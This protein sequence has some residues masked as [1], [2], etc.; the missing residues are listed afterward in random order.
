MNKII[1]IIL[2]LITGTVYAQTG[3]VLQDASM[4][5][6]AVSS[7]AEEI[8]AAMFAGAMDNTSGGNPLVDL[9]QNINLIAMIV[10]GIL[11]TYQIINAF[12]A[13]AHE[14]EFL[15]KKVNA[16]TYPLRIALASAV[17]V[18]IKSGYA[19]VQIVVMWLV[20]QSIGFADQTWISYIT[21]PNFNKNLDIRVSSVQSK[22]LASAILESTVCLE[23]LKKVTAPVPGNPITAEHNWGMHQTKNDATSTIKVF[24]DLNQAQGFRVD[25]CGLIDI[26]SPNNLFKQNEREN[27]AVETTVGTDYKKNSELTVIQATVIAAH[28]TA[29]DKMISSL[30][31]MAKEMIDNPEQEFNG[32]RFN[33]IV[34]EYNLYISEFAEKEMMKYDVYKTVKEQAINDGFISSMFLYNKMA[35]MA[36]IVGRSIVPQST[37][38]KPLAMTNSTYKDQYDIYM[39]KINGKLL[40]TSIKVSASPS[41]LEE[42]NEWSIR[43]WVENK[44]AEEV[45]GGAFQIYP[46]EHPIM[47]A[48]RMGTNLLNTTIGIT[49]SLLIGSLVGAGALVGIIVPTMFTVAG[50]VIIF[51]LVI[52][53]I[54]PMMYI[55]GS[56]IAWV[57]SVVEAV[58]IAPFWAVAHIIHGDDMLGSGE[59]G[60]KLL[61]NI[62]LKPVF[63]VVGVIASF[64]LIGVISSFIMANYS[65]IMGDLSSGNSV[66]I[67]SKFFYLILSY[68]VISVLMFTTMMSVMKVIF[69][70]PDRIMQWITNSENTLGGSAQDLA[71]AGSTAGKIATGGAALAGN[72]AGKSLKGGKDAFDKFKANT[73]DKKLKE[74]QSKA[75]EQEKFNGLSGLGK[76]QHNMGKDSKYGGN[77]SY[78]NV[79]AVED[80]QGMSGQLDGFQEGLGEQFASAYNEERGED[81]NKSDH[82][83]AFQNAFNKTLGSSFEPGSVQANMI[84]SMASDPKSAQSGFTAISKLKDFGSISTSSPE[85]MM[86]S[87]VAGNPEQ[88]NTGIEALSKLK[89]HGESKGMLAGEISKEISSFASNVSTKTNGFTDENTQKA[90][91]GEY[92]K[93][94]DKITTSVL[95]DIGV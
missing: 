62:L 72:V 42:N 77:N 15:G 8:M 50:P 71:G 12:I 76:L 67:L 49:F 29:L 3:S 46:N 75:Q 27:N 24:G 43:S 89:K 92:R 93:S 87:A 83:T 68:A 91:V 35:D 70:L 16:A 2:S 65:D 78:S 31:N 56:I 64:V 28:K 32:K 30:S 51:T 90:I 22:S 48:K 7:K 94:K 69:Q 82:S 54:T 80:V 14:G 81:G 45:N 86:L 9:I 39:N 37:P 36:D 40:T 73:N 11:I 57:I 10:A 20:V 74:S 26:Q 88:L 84:S 41:K 58:I 47:A 59:R 53:P 66:G 18:P 95:P 85:G 6:P 25:Q 4:F 23:A 33:S 21:S 63:I 34:N 38:N 13:T 19:L 1:T 44:I 17:I 60:Y 5:A 52:I 61:L 79:K 55:L